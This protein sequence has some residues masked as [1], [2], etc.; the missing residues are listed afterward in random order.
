MSTRMSIT[1]FAAI[2]IAGLAVACAGGG[3]A[4]TAPPMPQPSP[5]RIPSGP[6]THVVIIVQ[7]NRTPDFLFQGLPGAD[8]SK[9]AVDY[10]GQTVVLHPESLTGAYD[11]PHGYPNFVRDYNNGK[12]NGW[13]ERLKQ[14]QHLRP[15]G[16][17]PAS[18]VYPYHD[19]AAQHAF[20]DHMFQSNEGPSFPAHLYLISGSA[21]VTPKPFLVEDDP[22]SSVNGGATSGGCDA[23]KA[24]FV[25]TIDPKNAAPGPTPFPCFD[26]IVLSDL[27]DARHVSW[28]YYQNNKGGGLWQ[29]FDAVRHV[30]Y[31]PDYVNVIA[32][33]TQVLTDIASDRLANVTW[34]IPNSKW[35][36]HAGNRSA[37]GPAWVAAIVNALGQSRYWK[38]CAIFITWDDWGG[39]YDHVKPNLYN[40]YELGFRVP[41]IV[42]SP[43]AKRGYV[44]KVQHEFGSILAFTE[45]AFGIPKGSLQTTDLRADDLSDAFDFGQAMR[46][47]TPI[48]APPFSPSPIDYQHAGDEDP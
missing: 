37:E 25:L 13:D 22:H 44:S 20:A 32:P 4:V 2:V 16:Y 43:Y 30:R 47:F 9:T 12:M 26:P 27:L 31:G 40:H 15:F 23:P 11:P 14:S 38:S 1:S 35:S 21:A 18:E 33:Q 5:S 45:E 34:V 6:I 42:V 46:G 7:E 3:S 24:A 19:M 17:A 48:K 8:I 41:L 36:D 29:P 28:R 39:W 10:E